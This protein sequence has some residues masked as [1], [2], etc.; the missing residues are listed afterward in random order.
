MRWLWRKKTLFYRWTF[1][2]NPFFSLSL[3]FFLFIVFFL[4]SF[5]SLTN[6]PRLRATNFPLRPSQEGS[7]E[8]SSFSNSF[9]VL[10]RVTGYWPGYLSIIKTIHTYRLSRAGSI[11]FSLF[12]LMF[13]L[14]SDPRLENATFPRSACS[15]RSLSLSL[16]LYPGNTRVGSP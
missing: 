14:I 15:V 13:W 9:G 6:Q 11:V 5:R 8:E 12:Q 7:P 3:C 10:W 2:Y 16:S 4:F 1:S